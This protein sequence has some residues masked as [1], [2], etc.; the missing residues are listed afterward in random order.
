MKTTSVRLPEE[1]KQE[2]ASLAEANGMDAGDLIRMAIKRLL[3]QAAK[4]EPISVELK[5][6]R[7]GSSLTAAA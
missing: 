1:M 3:A 7:A 2:V 4:G 6:P 5:V